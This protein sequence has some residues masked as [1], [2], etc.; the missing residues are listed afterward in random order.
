MFFSLQQSLIYE[1]A[2]KVNVLW[3]KKRNK[4]SYLS[5]FYPIHFLW[6]ISVRTQFHRYFSIALHARDN[7]IEENRGSFYYYCYYYFKKSMERLFA[8]GG[9]EGGQFMV[10]IFPYSSS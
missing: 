8:G 4:S 2:K 9:G 7:D 10:E 3:G 6:R 1:K 5:P